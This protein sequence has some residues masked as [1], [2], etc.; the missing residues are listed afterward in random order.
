[1]RLPR[2]PR[3]PPK[4]ARVLW[5]V[6]WVVFAAITVASLRDLDDWIRVVGI[7]A[8]LVAAWL[9]WPE[10]PADDEGCLK[11]GHASMHHHGNCQACLR[12]VQDGVPLSAPVPCGRFERWSHA[13]TWGRLRAA[14]RSPTGPA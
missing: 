10:P 7:L 9:W 8:A 4:V 14:R 5:I 1:M 6:W 11:C 12:D 13:T 3:L 2:R